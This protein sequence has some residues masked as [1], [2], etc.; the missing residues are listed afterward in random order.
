MISATKA[1]VTTTYAL[2]A[3]GQRVKKTTSGS[4]T[5]FVYD[6][7]GHLVGEY[8]N[9]GN[10]L[11]ET[12]WFGDIPVATLRPNGGG[13]N[14]FYVHTDHLNTPRRIS[15]PSDNVVVWRWDGDPFGTT[16]ANE[17]P[18]G[19]SNSF[20]YALRFPG[21][22]F[23]SETGLHYNYQRDGYD[24]AVGRYTQSD[25]IGFEGGINTYAYV[26]GSPVGNSDPLGL[27]A[28]GDGWKDREWSDIQDAEDTIR[29]ELRKSCYCHA[30]RSAEGCIPC[31]LVDVLLNRLDTSSV[32]YL[33]LGGDCG[34]APV[35]HGIALSRNAWN[36][37]KC[38][39]LALTLYHEL[40]HNA[41]LEH[42]PTKKGP[43]INDLAEGRCTGNLCKRS[44][45]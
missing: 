44:V 7:A 31:D 12:V 34:W 21:Q 23:D 29:K 25:P 13:V 2:N 10:L 16:V 3:L 17:D 15:R 22:Y 33:P 39:C 43:G 30:E 14:V 38:G 37:R 19:D 1:S 45:R 4:S 35:A 28:R 41:G 32:R 9:S 26:H 6:E 40:L 5:Y 42:E 18:D 20:A 11:Q 27:L 8:D 36:R 24:P